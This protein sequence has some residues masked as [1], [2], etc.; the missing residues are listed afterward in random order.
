MNARESSVSGLESAA[1]RR[2]MFGEDP[3]CRT[4]ARP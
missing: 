4:S 2:R 1:T 3:G